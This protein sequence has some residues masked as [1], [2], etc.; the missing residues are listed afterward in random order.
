MH[1]VREEDPGFLAIGKRR[2][3]T[4]PSFSVTLSIHASPSLIESVV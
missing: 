4:A 3:Y 2:A 1:C